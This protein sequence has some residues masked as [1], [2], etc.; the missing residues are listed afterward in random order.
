M[1]G[2][3]SNS[4]SSMPQVQNMEPYS[5]QQMEI[6]STVIQV[7]PSSMTAREPEPVSP[8]DGTPVMMYP[9]Q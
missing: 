7:Q 2:F 5:Q 8:A 3:G 4:Y 9:L 6:G 1:S